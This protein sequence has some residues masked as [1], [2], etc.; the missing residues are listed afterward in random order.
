MFFDFPLPLPFNPPPP[1]SA[2]L[3]LFNAPL[4]P[5][6]TMELIGTVARLENLHPHDIIEAINTHVIQPLF[7]AIG[8]MSLLRRVLITWTFLYLGSLV[9]YF[10]FAT[11]DFVIYF[12]LFGHRLHPPGYLNTVDMRREI[13]MSVRSLVIM[14]L[15]STPAEVALQ[16]GYG[17]VYTNPAQYGY[18]YLC[19]SPLLFLMFSDCIIYFIHRG[20]HHRLIYKHVHKPHHSFINTTPYAAFAFH[21]LDGYLQGTSYQ[22]FVFL[23]PLQCGVHFLSLVIVSMWTINIHDR[24]AFRIPGINGAGHHKIHHTTFRSNYGQYTTLW[25][26][27]CGTFRDPMIWEK[28][29]APQISEKD[30]YGK[31]V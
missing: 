25:D 20:L 5:F 23:F 9:V 16:Y 30:A 8:P 11:L 19:I 21:P 22:I 31:D 6:F 2:S 29:G 17:K 18:F 26:K 3:P 13:T 14:A 10:F 28:E 27:L 12:K 15:M 7:P 24:V 4:P 1:S